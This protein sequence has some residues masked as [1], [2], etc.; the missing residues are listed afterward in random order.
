M[1]DNCWYSAQ[2]DFLCTKNKQSNLITPLYYDYAL[3]EQFSLKPAYVNQEARAGACKERLS[4]GS[5]LPATESEVSAK[6]Q[7][8]HSMLI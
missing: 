5:I 3:K 2:G 6:E 7:Q 1:N 4:H 8:A